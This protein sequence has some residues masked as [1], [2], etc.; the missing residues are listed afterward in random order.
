MH[1][2]LS[3]LTALL[4][5]L[6]LVGCGSAPRLAE[7]IEQLPER[8]ELDEVPFFPQ[9]EYQCG[10]AALAT[11]LK[12][13]GVAASPDLLKDRVFLP[14]RRG[15]LQVELVAAARD[16]DLLVYP[17][18]PRLDV[19]L[20]EVAAGNPVLVLQNL[21]F[22]WYPRWHFA[23]VVGYDRR[24]RQLILRSGTTR[25]W[26]SDFA[27]FDATW[28]R[29]GRWAVLTLPPERIPARAE[30]RPWLQ[31]AVDLEQTGHAGAAGR[32]YQAAV[33]HWPE[34]GISWFALGN[35]RYAAAEPVVAQRALLQAVTVEPPLAP[36]WGNLA[37]VLAEQGCTAQAALAQRCARRL[38][39]QEE[40]YAR[41]LSPAVRGGEC[42]ILPACPR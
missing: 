17:L 8:A 32:A 33:R 36:A 18:E 20:A 10:P 26:V 27:S 13:R 30:L 3:W 15:S 16:H 6:L 39:P 11:M 21:A 37:H 4:V 35:E 19:L 38:E 14:G 5:V 24:E 40:R 28:A 42:P 9:A 25:R 23:V 22:S 12:H 2:S 1:Q 29:G 34:E 41:A 7:Q 31:A